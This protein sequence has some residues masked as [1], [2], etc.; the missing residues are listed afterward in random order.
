MNVFAVHADMG[1]AAADSGKAVPDKA[2]DNTDRRNTVRRR[3]RRYNIGH[4]DIAEGVSADSPVEVFADNPAEV[5]AVN[6]AEVFVDNP[7]E[8]SAESLAEVSAVNPAELVFEAV[9]PAE[10]YAAVEKS[11]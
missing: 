1:T 10:R 5:F 8:V 11:V 3:I 2:H 7:V 6:L 9:L 4:S